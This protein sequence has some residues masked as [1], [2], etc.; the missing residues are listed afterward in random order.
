VVEEKRQ[1][2]EY[3]LKEELYN[4]RADVRPNV[5][6]K[7]DEPEGDVSGG[8][9]SMPNPSR[10][11]CCARKADLTPA[12]IAK[13]MARRL[14]KL[15][16]DADTAARMDARA[17]RHRAPRSAA[18]QPATPRSR[19]TAPLVLLAAA[20]TTPSTRVPEGSRALAGIGCHYMAMWMDRAHRDLHP[21]GRRGRA[22]GSG[23]A[24]FTTD[25][26]RVRQPRRRHLL[27]LRAAGDPPE[28][29]RRA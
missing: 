26:A 28:R 2:I 13:A 11:R 9:W 24:P 17:G 23:Q 6:G 1:V 14:K 25:D 4:W 15:G 7:F 19:A 21:D 16:V 20:R 22:P 3:Q 10:T 12:I 27:P 8:E 29:R 18:W 5:L